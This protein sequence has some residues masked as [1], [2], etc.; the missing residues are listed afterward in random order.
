M[1]GSLGSKR[2]CSERDTEDVTNN[3][4]K[5]AFREGCFDRKL[6]PGPEEAELNRFSEMSGRQWRELG[7]RLI[8]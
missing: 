8:E 1:E 7:Q 4:E 2:P 6:T 3:G 5:D